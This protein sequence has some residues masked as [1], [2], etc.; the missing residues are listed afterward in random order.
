MFKEKLEYD[1]PV[2]VSV[3]ILE[4]SQLHMYDVF[5]NILQPPLK[6]LQLHHMDTDL[7]VLN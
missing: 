4:V 5:Y 3:T 6:D 2:Y 1:S 7:Y